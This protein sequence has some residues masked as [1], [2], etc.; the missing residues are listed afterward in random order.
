MKLYVLA[1][2]KTLHMSRGAGVVD[3]GFE[4]LEYEDR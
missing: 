3:E 4:F 2:A 1:S